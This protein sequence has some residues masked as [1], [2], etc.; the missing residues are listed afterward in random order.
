M[1]EVKLEG[2]EEIKKLFKGLPQVIQTI[3][4]AEIEEGLREFVL[5]GKKPGR[6]RIMLHQIRFGT[7]WRNWVSC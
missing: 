3:A 4:D 1:V 7:S 5:L 2:L 6:E